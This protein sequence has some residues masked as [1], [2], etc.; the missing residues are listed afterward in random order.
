MSLKH[1]ILGLLN[2]QPM[3]GYDLKHLAFDSTVSHFWQADQAQIYRTLD[4]LEEEG[5]LTSQLEIQT[6][7]PNRRVY[8]ITPTGR[9]EL[10]RWLKEPQSPPV[11]REPFLVQMFFGYL[12]DDQDI[13]QHLDDHIAHHQSNLAKYQHIQISPSDETNIKRKQ[14]F[15][16][17]TLELGMALEKTYVDW[18]EK[19]K[20]TIQNGG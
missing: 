5:L 4:K 7:R 10:M 18:L 16:R 1:A 2:I 14:T 6:D 11:Y 19:C 13:L 15:W 12:L 8:H 20:A 17:L 3:T 9:D